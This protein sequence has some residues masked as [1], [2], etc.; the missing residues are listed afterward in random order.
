[1]PVERWTPERR[2]ELTRSALLAAA[3]DVFSRRGFEGASLEEIAEAAGFTR[4]AIYKNF[5]SKA[6]LFFA[7]SDRDYTAKLQSFSER[8]DHDAEFLDPADLAALW[9]ETVAGDADL[10]LNMEVR[11]YAMRNPE[12]RARFAEHQRAMRQELS[13]FIV[14]RTEGAGF[15][16]TIPAMTLAGL[17][18]AAS[19]GIV[20][21]TAIDDA[22]APLLES[23]F[24]LIVNAACDERPTATPHGSA[25]QESIAR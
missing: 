17:L 24:A 22:D 11:L 23:F 7:V 3:A 2:R 25:Q 20:E 12:V 21:S 14:D 5:G 19:W 15:T 8:L 10:A 18:D 1:M 4:G 9:R 13:Q 16:L 6:E